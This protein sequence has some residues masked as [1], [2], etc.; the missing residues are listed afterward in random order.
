MSGLRFVRMGFGTEAVEYQAAWDEQRRVH[1]ARFADEVP[2]TVLLLEHPPVYTAG[3]RTADNERPLDGTP[4]IDVDR[5][6][7]ITWHG[8]GQLVGYPIQKLPRPVDV[9]AHVRR[10]EEALIRTCA[11]FG[12]ETTRVEGR[13]GVWVLGDPVEQRLGGLSLHLDPRLT[14][15]EFDPRMNGPEYAPSNAGQRREDRKIAAIGIRVAKGVTMHGFALNVNPDNKWFDR[16]I[17]CG[18]RDAGV[19]SLAGEL[20]RDITIAEVLPVA[21][22]H[23]RDVLENADLQPRVVE[24]A[25][26]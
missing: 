8:P 12:V 22:R 6:G 13:S 20:G 26:A 1:A 10:L 23:L 16:I 19:A 9:V 15:D 7:K 11:E 18:I 21:E 17:P 5:G 14:D 3:R 4:V 25:S 24:R 2:D